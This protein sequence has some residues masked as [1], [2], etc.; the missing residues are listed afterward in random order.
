MIKLKARINAINSIV[1][2]GEKEEESGVNREV[3][4]K[5]KKNWREFD[6]VQYNLDKVDMAIHY[7]DIAFELADSPELSDLP[8][9]PIP[10]ILNCKARMLETVGRKEQA[11]K[12]YEDII[13]T[14]NTNWGADNPAYAGYL[15]AAKSGI[16]RCQEG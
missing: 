10:Y 15:V 13:E 9:N 1:R 5:L 12:V 8:G 16:S 3:G 11:I 14:V 2:L 4:A 6:G 7:F